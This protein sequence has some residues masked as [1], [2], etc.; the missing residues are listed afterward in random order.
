MTETVDQ[1]QQKLN[2]EAKQNE[3]LNVDPNFGGD[4]SDSDTCV[5]EQSIAEQPF[6]LRLLFQNDW[7]SA[8][9]SSES[10]AI[11]G[12]QTT[13]SAYLLYLAKRS[14]QKLIP[15]K[16]KISDH[17]DSASVWL[18][19]LHSFFPLPFSANC[20]NQVIACYEEMHSPSVDTLRLASWL[21]TVA[22]IA[23]Q[24]PPKHGSMEARVNERERQ[25]LSKAI[26]ETVET[27]ILAHDRLAGS[28]QGLSLSMQCI[29]L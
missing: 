26:S 9:K 11:Q 4:S 1:M 7:L 14:L 27:K 8:E 6:H 23:E 15:S 29:R 24:L 28:V 12:H 16:D 5:S 18:T 17:A 2:C 3:E 25:L 22:L 21:L 10:Q 13:H 20:G 19:M